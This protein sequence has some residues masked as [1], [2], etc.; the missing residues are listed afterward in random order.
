[1]KKSLLTTL[2]LVLAMVLTSCM[3]QEKMAQK[4]FQYAEEGNYD[5]AIKLY[6]QLIEKEPKNPYNYLSLSNIY[7]ILEDFQSEKSILEEGINALEY[8]YLLKEPLA[9]IY[10]RDQ[11]FDEAEKVLLE[12]FEE[13]HNFDDIT[14]L[15][16]YHTLF[17]IYSLQSE[18]EKM[19]ELF[20]NNED[21]I[22]SNKA[23]IFVAVSYLDM[24]D[25]DRARSIIDN[26]DT[27]YIDNHPELLEK[28]A[29]FYLRTDDKDNA[30]QIAERGLRNED[31]TI[32]QGISYGLSNDHGLSLVVM[33]TGDINGDEKKENV[34]MMADDQGWGSEIIQLHI[35]EGE[36]GK[37]IDTISVDEIG[38]YPNGLSL[39]DLNHDGILDMLTSVHSGGTGGMEY[40]YAYSYA[41]NNKIDL[42]DQFQHSI[43]FEFYDGF[44]AQVFSEEVNKAFEVEF[45]E[46]RKHMYVEHGYYTQNGIMSPTV[47]G[48]FR[49]DML[50]TTFI[51]ELNKYG[52]K[53]ST[54][55]TGPAYNADSIAFIETIFL[56]D[57]GRWT[58]YDL[59]VE[60]EISIVKTI[61]FTKEKPKPIMSN[62]FDKLDKWFALTENDIYN[63]Y[64]Q[65]IETG[66]YD[67]N[68]LSYANIL[69][70]VDQNKVTALSLFEGEELFG[71][72]MRP[73]YNDI[74]NVLG[75][76][77]SEEISEYDGDYTL[78]YELGGY[79]IS[80]FAVDK[81]DTYS[82]QI[83]NSF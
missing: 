30:L 48:Y 8:K 83:K 53:H 54:S 58:T 67:G 1:M 55:L 82:I 36:T 49:G 15:N 2:I 33:K 81:N 52:L 69:F 57:N 28:L 29:I 10:I 73:K 7:N 65:P 60:D 64:G 35:Q 71:M 63:I 25:W 38:G 20:E 32:F 44:K 14:N 27:V 9:Q 11:Q 5:E 76:P 22:D 13:T 46:G 23:D 40:H 17:D 61:P 24:G 19:I 59:N 51:E 34:L 12:V 68:Y 77:Q 72:K 6:Q 41:G 47:Y 79:Y 80:F 78:Y 75:K 50:E 39:A 43:D 31:N 37:I 56:Y 4:A 3:S 16:T 21:K 66:W 42:L 74:I 26:A 62:D 70:F 45:D 18:S